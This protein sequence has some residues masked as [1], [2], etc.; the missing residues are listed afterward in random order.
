MIGQVLWDMAAG[1][2]DYTVVGETE[3][4]LTASCATNDTYCVLYNLKCGQV[5]HVSVTANNQ[6][7]QGVSTSTEPA[8]I[9][10]GEKTQII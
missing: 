9:A 3:Q 7:C 6:A 5:Y 10:T 8:I 4:G 2:D 1:A